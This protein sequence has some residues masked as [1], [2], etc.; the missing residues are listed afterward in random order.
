M[1]T[2]SCHQSRGFLSFFF[3]LPRLLSWVPFI[4]L[5]R[6]GVVTG[7][8]KDTNFVHTSSAAIFLSDS[9]RL[10]RH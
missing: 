9:R 4:I 1:G 7:L 8:S 3:S 2:F 5:A 6:N 10:S